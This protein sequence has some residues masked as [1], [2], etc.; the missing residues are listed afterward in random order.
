MRN[1]TW[2]FTKK[3]VERIP[4]WTSSDCKDESAC[5]Q[6]HV[7]TVYD[8]K[9]ENVVKRCAMVAKMLIKNGSLGHK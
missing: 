4:Y 1:D 2:D 6:L 7:S 5:A 9:F 8:K 3:Y